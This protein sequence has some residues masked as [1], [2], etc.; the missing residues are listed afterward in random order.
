MLF[1]LSTLD[2]TTQMPF[3]DRLW[4]QR[5]CYYMGVQ[6]SLLERGDLWGFRL[7]SNLDECIGGYYHYKGECAPAM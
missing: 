7:E 3:G 4:V 6:I 5:T 1:V 2:K